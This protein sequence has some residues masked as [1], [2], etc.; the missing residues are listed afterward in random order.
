MGRGLTP[1]IGGLVSLSREAFAPAT[2]VLDCQLQHCSAEEETEARWAW[3]K[4][5]LGMPAQWE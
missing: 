2:G 3:E 5:L 1:G 4:W